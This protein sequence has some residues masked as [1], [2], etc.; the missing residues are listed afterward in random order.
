MG[1]YSH[2]VV[3]EIDGRLFTFCP[4]GIFMTNL[5]SA[6]SIGEPVKEFWKNFVPTY[7]AAYGVLCINTFAWTSKKS[8]F[9]YIYDI[10]VPTVT[11]DVVLEYSTVTNAWTIHDGGYTN[12]FHVNQFQLS[13]FGDVTN[14]MQAA[15]SQ[16]F[17]HPTLIGGDSSGKVW[18][19]EEN[20]FLNTSLAVIGSDIYVDLRSDTG[21]PISTVMETQM[22]DLTHPE[23]FKKFKR[24]RVLIESGLW[25]FEYRI[26][27]EAGV[28]AY[29]TLGSVSST[30]T[31]LPFPRE[32]QGWSVGF[33]ISGVNTNGTQ[34]LNGFV[35]EETEVIPRS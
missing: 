22:Y 27:D 32:A 23:L 16:I 10:T 20:R 4:N 6:K 13:R 31:V 7:D 11:N 28:S 15:N 18:R 1:A 26:K 9:L 3:H 5:F 2:K 17:R 35:F 12:F 25:N 19:L 21:N 29:R 14:N 33:R 24:L 8:Y 30:N 34:T